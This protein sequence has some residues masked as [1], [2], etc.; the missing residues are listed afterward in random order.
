MKFLRQ[1][2]ILRKCGFWSKES[3]L[4]DA[5]SIDHAGYSVLPES[6]VGGDTLRKI[7]LSFFVA[8]F[9][10]GILAAGSEPQVVPSIVSGVP[11]SVVYNRFIG[12]GNSFQGEDQ[13]MH[14]REHPASFVLKLNPKRVCIIGSS[15]SPNDDSSRL[16]GAPFIELSPFF[17]LSEVVPRP[18]LPDQ[19]SSFLVVREALLQEI[20][21]WQNNS[22][23]HNR[24]VVME[25]RRIWEPNTPRCAAS[26]LTGLTNVQ[27]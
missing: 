18:D 15:V 12:N 10:T 16:S 17:F 8:A 5:A 6:S 19:L 13:S 2:A 27:V 14:S 3:V 21:R 20:L 22:G 25:S 11:V 23:F 26:F 7:L 4:L 1:S 9:V 24:S